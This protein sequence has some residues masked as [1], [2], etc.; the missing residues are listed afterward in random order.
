VRH[1]E[2]L[3]LTGDTLGAVAKSARSVRRH[4]GDARL[5][6]QYVQLVG[7]ESGVALLRG[8]ARFPRSSGLRVVAAQRARS[9][10]DRSAER[11]ELGAAVAEDPAMGQG[12]LRIAELWF[13]D[14]HADSALTALGRAP[15][16]GTGA[17]LLRSYAIGRG[18]Q[19]L[20]AA[21]DSLPA[22]Y[23]VP[24]GL[25]AL[26]DSVE[27]HE[28]SRGLLAAALLQYSRS[29]LVVASVSRACDDARRSDAGL[30]RV[31]TILDRGVGTGT[32]ADELHAAQDTLRTAIDAAVRALCAPPMT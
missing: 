24:L 21:V 6:L 29:E 14:G 4:P 31:R 15:R 1:V 5:Y 10:G 26:A 7:S 28:D 20:Q 16:A 25:L 2:A 27:S 23:T 18:V 17:T 32:A 11:T 3:R 19:L 30:A 9:T 22:T 12:Y 8:L 13:L